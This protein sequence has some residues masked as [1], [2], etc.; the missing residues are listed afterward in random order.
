MPVRHQSLTLALLLTSTLGAQGFTFTSPRGYRDAEGNDSD[1]ALLGR[2]VRF[3]QIDASG[4]GLFPVVVQSIGWRRDGPR[5]TTLGPQ[6]FD[7]EVFF[8]HADFNTIGTNLDNNYRTGTRTQVQRTTVSLPDWTTAVGDAAPF[9]LVVP[10]APWAYN[11]TDA[12]VWEVVT[13]NWPRTGGVFPDRATGLFGGGQLDAGRA[14]GLGCTVLGRSAPMSTLTTAWNYGPSHPQFGMRICS[15]L[16]D[17]V[18]SAPV[19]MNFDFTDQ[20]VLLPGACTRLHAGPLVSG[21]IGTTDGSG[22]LRQQCFDFPHIPGT[23][24]ARFVAQ[25][26]M[27]DPSQTGFPIAISN[28]RTLTMPNWTAT[29]LRSAY[30]YTT[31]GSSSGALLLRNCG[32]VTQ[33][34]F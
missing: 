28:G 14:L 23:V 34:R 13:R 16:I 10:I 27:L 30:V 17:G 2:D 15:E 19:V 29:L 4:I 3:Q 26:F 24:G 21:V 31:P 6:N 11:G 5:R 20:D 32:V 1:W 25:Y 8:G 12:L 33:F 22:R 9:D 18:A 7:I